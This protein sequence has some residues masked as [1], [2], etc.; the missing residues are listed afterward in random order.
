M[1]RESSDRNWTIELPKGGKDWWKLDRKFLYCV[2]VVDAISSECVSG[3]KIKTVLVKSNNFFSN[4]V[5]ARRP[6]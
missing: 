6:D 3:V 2:S 1:E 4:S 5:Q